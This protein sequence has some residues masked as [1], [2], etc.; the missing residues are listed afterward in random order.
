V[1]KHRIYFEYIL[2]KRE[3]IIMEKRL[4]KNKKSYGENSLAKALTRTSSSFE[5]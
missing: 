3:K 5:Y 1:Q 4:L 2:N